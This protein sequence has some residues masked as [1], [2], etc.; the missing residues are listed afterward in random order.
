MTVEEIQKRLAVFLILLLVMTSILSLR[1]VGLQLVNGEKYEKLSVGN[2]LRVIPLQAP[3]GD[4]LDRNLQP[5][6]SSRPAFSVSIML[7][8]PNDALESAKKLGA[9]IGKDPGELVRKVQEGLK[10]RPFDSVKVAS[11]ISP[12][13]H[14]QIAEMLDELPGVVIEAEPIRYYPQG[15]LAAHVLGYVHE[16]SQEQLSKPQFQS[17]KPG[18]LVG[19]FG[20]E[21]SYE[22]V[23]RGTNGGKQVEVDATGHPRSILGRTE[24]IPGQTILTTIDSRI[25]KVAEEA[26]TEQMKRLRESPGRP[27]PN[28]KS[29][30]VVV[31]DVRTGAVLALVSLPSFDPNEFARGI[32]AAKFNE[33]QSQNAFVD[34]AISLAYPPGST[35]KMVTAVAALEEKK[36]AKD[37]TVYDPG[38]HPAVP[39][40][41]CWGASGHGAVNLV[42]AIKESCNVFFYEMGRRLGLDAI[43]KYAARFG[44]GKQTGVDLYGEATGLLPTTSWKKSVYHEDVLMAENMMAGM[45]QTFH[46][47]TPI[48]LANYIATL[49]TGVRHKPFLVQKV[50][51]PDGKIVEEKVPVVEDNLGDIKPETLELVRKGMLEVTKPGG[52]AA[53]VFAGLPIDVAG[54]TGTAENSLGDNHA[55][56]V[57]YAPFQNPEIAVCVLIEQGGHGSSAAAPV[58]RK[59]FEAYFISGGAN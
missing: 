9:I 8:N 17:Y 21:A 50:I 38:Y 42:R 26:L 11:D 7:L 40:L 14:T 22:S 23:L 49:A 20:L 15:S 53:G 16:I 44:L 30:A 56:F 4:I 37:E 28:A 33:L 34:R 59:I 51:A 55:W 54:K 18:D 10:L 43:A 52:T 58:A 5:L 13:I 3:R 39:S 57:G 6:A 29:G 48:Q 2:K 46:L 35:F 24:P 32:S 47:Y 45:G 36:V 27:F 12:E 31:L 1:L 41:H 25:Q 19:Q